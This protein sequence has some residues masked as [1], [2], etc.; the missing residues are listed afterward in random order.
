MLKNLNKL[1]KVPIK[2]K[3]KDRNCEK[4]IEFLTMHEYFNRCRCEWNISRYIKYVACMFILNKI[5]FSSLDVVN[6]IQLIHEHRLDI[7]SIILMI[8]K[9]KKFYDGMGVTLHKITR[10]LNELVK[11]IERDGVE[12]VIKRYVPPS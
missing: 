6:V 4:V 11:E 7:K 12:K 2:V 9:S 5:E 1:I 10:T 8:F 3:I